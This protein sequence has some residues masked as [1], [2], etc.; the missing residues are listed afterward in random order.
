VNAI[1]GKNPLY[2]LVGGARVGKFGRLATVAENRRNNQAKQQ[3]GDG[4]RYRD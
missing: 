1:V 2:P 4:G 3:L